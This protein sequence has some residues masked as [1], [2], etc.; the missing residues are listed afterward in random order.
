MGRETEY[1][2][3]CVLEFASN[4]QCLYTE[5]LKKNV[6]IQLLML[7]ERYQ[8]AIHI[9]LTIFASPHS[10]TCPLSLGWGFFKDSLDASL[11]SI[12]PARDGTLVALQ[13]L[14]IY[15]FI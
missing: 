14:Y 2:P 4:H 13:I 7:L 5:Q 15:F 6:Q 1:L 8:F 12:L 9:P 3:S 11:I 10:L